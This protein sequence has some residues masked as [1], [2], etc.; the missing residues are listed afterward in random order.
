MEEKFSKKIIRNKSIKRLNPEEALND[1]LFESNK[2]IIINKE[3]NNFHFFIKKM[4]FAINKNWKK[5][6]LTFLL[7]NNNFTPKEELYELKEIYFSFDKNCDGE[8]SKQEEGIIQKIDI[9]NNGYI[10]FEEFCKAL[11]NK[12][13]NFD[14]TRFK[15]SF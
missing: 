14:W 2:N 6:F 12:K 5:Q 8:I 11:I 13:K 7:H 10:G 15:N 3:N 9:D 1:V 4:N